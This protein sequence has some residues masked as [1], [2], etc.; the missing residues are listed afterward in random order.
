MDSKFYNEC[1]EDKYVEVIDKWRIF[2]K[3]TFSMCLLVFIYFISSHVL[4]GIGIYFRSWLG[5]IISFIVIILIVLGGGAAFYKSCSNNTSVFAR[6]ILGIVLFIMTGFILCITLFGIILSSTTTTMAYRDGELVI[7]ES[8]GFL[9]STV[10]FYKPINIFLMKDSKLESFSYDGG[11]N[12]Y[13]FKDIG[14]D[15]EKTD[16]FDE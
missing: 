9:N 14:E 8:D 11:M 7:A 6:V 12:I 3:I 13:S 5:D 4:G 1:K 15:F 16:G 2:R 10:D